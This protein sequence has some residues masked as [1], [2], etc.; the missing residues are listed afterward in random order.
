MNLIMNFIGAVPIIEKKYFI[1]HMP[2]GLFGQMKKWMK[3]HEINEW[4]FMK[5]MNE[6]SWN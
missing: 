1:I 5:L 6:N 3:I 2:H 4:K